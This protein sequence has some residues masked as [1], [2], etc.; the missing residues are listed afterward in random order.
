MRI[1]DIKGFTLIEVMIAIGILGLLVAVAIPQYQKFLKK[2]KQVE[3]EQSLREIERLQSAYFVQY[4]A[5]APDIQTLGYAPNGKTPYTFTVTVIA[6][7]GGESGSSDGSSGSGSGGS[8]GSGGGK[9][10]GKEKEK[11]KGQGQGKSQG[12]GQSEGQE[13]SPTVVYETSATANLD[14]DPD[15]DAWM[16]TK[17]SDDSS[18]MMH[19]CIPGG[20]GAFISGCTD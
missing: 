1:R 8:D 20:S 19:G 10:K 17:L 12:Q 14:D 5:Y 7:G 13:G 9:A 18:H 16:L 6:G 11:Q 15:L 2:A 3:V 4:S